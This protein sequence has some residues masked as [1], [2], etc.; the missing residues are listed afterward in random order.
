MGK[1]HLKQKENN[2]VNQKTERQRKGN[3][4]QVCRGHFFSSD[5]LLNIHYL[6]HYYKEEDTELQ[7]QRQIQISLQFLVCIIR[8]SQTRRGALDIFKKKKFFLLWLLCF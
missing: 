6:K 5:L 3:G 8:H 1:K 2:F 7:M 4:G